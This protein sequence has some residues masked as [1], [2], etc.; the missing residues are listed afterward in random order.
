MKTLITHPN[1]A[2]LWE[3][4]ARENKDINLAKVKFEKFKDSWPNIFIEN[5]KDDIENQEITYIWD[6]SRPEFLFENYSIVRA[7]A[8]YYADKIKVIV[9]FFPV[10]TMERIQTKWEVATSRYMADILSHIPSWNQKTSIHIFDIHSLE[11]RFFFDD[12]KV[13]AELHTAIDIIKQ[14]IS[15]QT[16]IVFPDEWA[17][18]RFWKNFLDFENIYCSKQRID[19]KRIITINWWDVLDK[20]VL[21]VDDLIQS[22]GTIIETAKK[23]KELWAKSVSAF[24]THWVFVEDSLDKLSLN[25]DKIYTTD[26]LAKNH[27]LKSINNNLEVLSIKKLVQSK[28]LHII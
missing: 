18:K 5:V 19:D 11:Q 16:V 26:T 14:K 12:F 20:E 13:N 28:I 25:L 22:W 6:Y 21:I 10:W 24:A 15:P 23:L 4:I 27:N 7:L 8:W 1:F 2:Y 3:E 9:P 17:K